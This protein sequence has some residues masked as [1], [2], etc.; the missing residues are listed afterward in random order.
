M[1]KLIYRLVRFF[2]P[3]FVMFRVGDD[4]I[5]VQ[6]DDIVAIVPVVDDTGTVKPDACV[7]KLKNDED[8]EVPYSVT[9]VL[10][11]FDRHWRNVGVVGPVKPE[12]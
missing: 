10:K 2:I 4:G 12:R 8:V 7:L 3:Q 11:T 9:V 1:T 6:L 5:A